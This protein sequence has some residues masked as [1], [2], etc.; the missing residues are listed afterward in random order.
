M[1]F[2]TVGNIVAITKEELRDEMM[3][4][5]AFLKDHLRTK[6][7]DSIAIGTMYYAEELGGMYAELNNGIY[8]E[9]ENCDY[10]E[11]LDM[12]RC[13]YEYGV[14]TQEDKIH[15]AEIKIESLEKEIAR[16]KE[17][18]PNR[19][20][21]VGFSVTQYRTAEIMAATPEE[22]KAKVESLA[23]SEAFLSDVPEI[24]NATVDGEIFGM[25]DNVYDAETD[26]KLIDVEDADFSIKL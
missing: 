23:N 20:Y 13:P 26:E 16:L 14:A 1:K 10:S 7:C 4:S 9:E 17:L 21:E 3:R 19:K 25:V 5:A 24:A 11:A 22:A 8:L 12:M 6:G 2:N 18:I 15:D